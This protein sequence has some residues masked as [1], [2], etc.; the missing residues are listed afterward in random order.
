M[1]RKIFY[2]NPF[3]VY[4]RGSFVFKKKKKKKK[5]KGIYRVKRTYFSFS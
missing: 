5:V 4:C 2:P 1:L 3:Y